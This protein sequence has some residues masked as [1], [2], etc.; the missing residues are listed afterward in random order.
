MTS[1]TVIIADDEPLARQRLQRLLSNMPNIQVLAQAENGQQVLE[2]FEQHKPDLLILDINMPGLNGLSAAEKVVEIQHP[3]PAI[4][5]CTAY[6]EFA[7]DAF[8][9]QASGYLLK[10]INQADL[11]QAIDKA[12]VASSLQ[13]AQTNVAEDAFVLFVDSEDGTARLPLEKCIYF[14][15]KDKYVLAGLDDGTETLVS[16]SLKELEDRFSAQLVRTHRSTLAN[17][18]YLDGL[19][20]ADSGMSVSLIGSRRVLPVSRRH[21]QEV[22]KCFVN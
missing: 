8:K 22:K 21:L 14:R 1:I 12:R 20:K 7:L 4:I 17:R 16:L 13:Q 18:K 19:H 2:L 6:E 15:A 11:S 5:F 3:P 9:V 10:P